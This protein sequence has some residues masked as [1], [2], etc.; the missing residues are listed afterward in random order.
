[1]S[2][3]KKDSWVTDVKFIFDECARLMSVAGNGLKQIPR[4]DSLYMLPH[5]SGRGSMICGRA[6]AEK[7]AGLA[8][9]AAR[10]S[11]LTRRI[12]HSTIR[13]PV[14]YLL[15]NRF[16]K[17]KRLL[18]ITE[19]DRVLAAAARQAR[20]KLSTTTHLVPCHLISARDPA[21][22]VIGPVKFHNRSSIRALLLQRFR[23]ARSVDGDDIEEHR[24]SLLT[25]AIRYYRNF[26][27]VAEVQVAGYD[28][29]TSA[30]VAKYA[31]TAALDCIHILFGFER[32]DRMQ[33]G[34]V[35]MRM[36]RRAMLTISESGAVEPS[37]SATAFGHVEYQDGW[38]QVLDTEEFRSWADLC[39]VALEAA[40]DLDLNRPLSRRFLDA[41][42]WFG[43]GCREENASTRTIKFMTAVE[44]LLTTGERDDVSRMIGERTAN[45][46][47]FPNESR[48]QW[49]EKALRAY[50][51]RSR[52][53][54]GS[55]S[56]RDPEAWRGARLAAEVS[57][58][59]L[60][61]VLETFEASGLRAPDMTERQLAKW[62][63][64]V[65]IW[66]EAFQSA[67][68]S[69]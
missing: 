30:E 16:M 28:A 35:A 9:E 45:L 53:V 21:Q 15:V 67:H 41:V 18:N 56:P 69:N 8:N 29:N 47:F 7:V 33:V 51:Y 24:R 43:E 31:V 32:T 27:W 66:S 14:E 4:E 5:P 22:I 50:D 59:V 2:K 6:A 36:D 44:R 49:M 23:E 40:V 11:G 17:E 54:H 48:N 65:E 10:R 57:Q 38:S 55:M 60:L 42:Q 63:E 19:V 46:C 20:S 34:G 12:E 68:S 13:R 61:R 25:T 39:G 37:L 1:M 58:A 62:F 64:R 3:N 26:R 52:L